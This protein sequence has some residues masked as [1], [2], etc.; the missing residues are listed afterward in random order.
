VRAQAF[1]RLRGGCGKA[2]Q[3]LDGAR[4]GATAATRL[5]IAAP[6][7]WPSSTQ[8]S[9]PSASMIASTCTIAC[10]VV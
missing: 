10:G 9:Q 2:A 5:A 4:C 6:I 3:R 7:E 8:R 1:D